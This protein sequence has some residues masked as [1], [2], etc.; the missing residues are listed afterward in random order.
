M[1]R[2]KTR[3][4]SRAVLVASLGVLFLCVPFGR[5]HQ[6]NWRSAG[7]DSILPSIA[8]HLFGQ[9][10]KIFEPFKKAAAGFSSTVPALVLF[11]RV[12][13]TQALPHTFDFGT[14][15][16]IRAPPIFSSGRN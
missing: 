9:P 15:R 4:I 11:A 10:C 13:L 8:G 12:C 6:P 5:T 2:Q 7:Y 16:S 3:Y 1:Q 14:H